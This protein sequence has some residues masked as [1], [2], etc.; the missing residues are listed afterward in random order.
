MLKEIQEI[1]LEIEIE[2]EIEE[3]IEIAVEIE[4]VV[5]TETAQE[6]LKMLICNDFILIKDLKQV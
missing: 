3:E 5:E 6:I 4:I 2:E 1:E